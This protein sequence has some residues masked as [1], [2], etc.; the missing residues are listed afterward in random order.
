[1]AAYGSDQVGFG[2]KS[3]TKGR[4]AIQNLKE[5]KIYQETYVPLNEMSNQR[6]KILNGIIN[7]P[8]FLK[9]PERNRKTEGKGLEG[10]G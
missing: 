4:S 10:E 3:S 2:L 5:E 8:G 1:M 9:I 6:K 7:Q